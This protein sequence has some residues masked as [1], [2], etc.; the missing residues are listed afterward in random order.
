MLVI[1]LVMVTMLSVFGLVILV[2]WPFGHGHSPE[3]RIYGYEP[4]TALLNLVMFAY[5]LYM[6]ICAIMFRYMWSA[7]FFIHH[8]CVVVLT[9]L[10]LRPLFH[11]YGFFFMGLIEISSIFVGLIDIFKAHPELITLHNQAYKNMCLL[12]SISFLLLRV[13]FWIP[14]SI[15]FWKDCFWALENH[16]NSEGGKNVLGNVLIY[17]IG[18]I[19]FTLLQLFWAKKIVRIMWKTIPRGKRGYQKQ[20]HAGSGLEASS[21]VE[22]ADEN[23]V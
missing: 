3:E 6:L 7:A 13:V 21:H 15:I 14:M 23:N 2:A 1:S 5:Q 17:L 18:N 19:I 20:Q 4:M 11:F 16:R 9:L 22:L 12:F 10:S 8:S